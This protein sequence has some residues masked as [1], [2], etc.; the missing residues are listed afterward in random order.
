G[1]ALCDL[2]DALSSPPEAA[3]LYARVLDRLPTGPH[4][5]VR[6]RA[7]RSLLA[8][9][10]SDDPLAVSRETVR[11]ALHLA[12]LAP[13]D[14]YRAHLL[15]ENAWPI[16]ADH[17]RRCSRAGAEDEAHQAVL[18]VHG[19]ILMAGRS[20]EHTSELQSRENLV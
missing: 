10:V 3:E 18:H 16:L 7:A 8:L 9:G 12:A 2:A 4:A 17:V 11:A 14:P 6:L 19:L 13:D 15:A 5:S 20:E 1:H